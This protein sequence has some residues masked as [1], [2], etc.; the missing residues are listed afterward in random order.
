MARERSVDA[1][2][3]P[4][5]VRREVAR[6]AALSVV[7]IALIGLGGLWA[8]QTVATAEAVHQAQQATE[9]LAAAVI[10]PAVDDDLVEGDPDAIADLDAVVQAAVVGEQVLTVRVWAP[11]GTVLYSDDL[12]DIGARFPLGA[13]EQEVL[14]TGESHA[15]LSDLGKEE[16][17]DQADFDQLLEVYV[18]IAD[19]DGNPLLFETYQATD[20]IAATTRRILL[21]FAPLVLGGLMLFGAIQVLLNWRLARRLER[22]QDERELLLHQALAASE[23]ERRTIA[24]DLHDGVVQDLVGLTYVLDGIAPGTPVPEG[25]LS[26]AAGTARRSV[27]SLRSLLVEIYPPNLDEVGLAGALAD[28]AAAAEQAGVAVSVEVDPG[29]QLDGP[30]TRAAYRAAREALSNVRRH[31]GAARATIRVQP[32][33][34][35]RGAILTVTDDGV[36]F[37]PVAVPEDHVGLRLLSDLATSLGGALEVDSAPGRGTTVRLVVPG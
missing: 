16:N 31:S 18:A 20:G 32:G 11:D 5:T 13:A 14:A 17:A 21:G 2:N 33:A 1:Q 19:P 37:D 30:G 29:V 27:R 12:A 28:L 9:L 35:G 36:G 7:A 23:H 25:A 6:S 8:A 24:A 22:A 34:D 3:G 4:V 26:T 10:E 15:H